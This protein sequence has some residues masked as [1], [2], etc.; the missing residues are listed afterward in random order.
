LVDRYALQRDAA[1]LLPAER[2]AQC[3][4][5]VICGHVQIWKHKEGRTFFGN[6]YT[7]GSVWQCP[8]CTVKVSEKRRL[9]LV[10][11]VD[12]WKGQG[13]KVG[14]LTLTAPHRKGESLT[15]LVNGLARARQ[16]FFNSRAWRTAKKDAGIVGTVTSSEVTYGG[17]GW[18]PHSH[19]LVF[20]TG[21]PP[22]AESLLTQWKASCVAAGLREPNG[23]GLTWQDG[24]K[25]AEYAAKWG[26]PEEVTRANTKKG[27]E[28]QRTPWDLLRDAGNGDVEAGEL[29]REYSYVFKGKR[30]LVWSKGL[31]DLLGLGREKDDEE[32]AEEKTEEAALVVE[33]DPEEWKL[34][35]GNDMR[36]E[37]LIAAREGGAEAVWKM[38]RS[39]TTTA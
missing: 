3:G 23:H 8:V 20:L 7:C 18:H 1:A 6:L 26:L 25:A 17:N 36:A 19:G 37:V 39:L 27:R 30:Q 13:H 31:R 11:A 21:A 15:A 35:L 38:L 12:A 5:R 33:L 9:E 2:V 4:V 28:G 22:D 16:H 24:S 32:L 34:V 14:L 10:A 29:F